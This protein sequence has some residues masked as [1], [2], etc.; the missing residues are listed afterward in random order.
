MLSTDAGATQ[1]G[2]THD[3]ARPEEEQENIRDETE[4]LARYSP[5]QYWDADTQEE[6]PP[7]LTSAARKEESDFMHEWEVWDVVPISG[8]WNV[9]GKAPL[10]GKWVDVNKGDLER[11][12]IRSR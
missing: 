4:S 12:V 2:T 9:T 10:Q 5:Q 7:D 11:P 3:E 1:S 8:S 6:L